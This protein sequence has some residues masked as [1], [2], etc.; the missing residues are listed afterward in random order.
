MKWMRLLSQNQGARGT[1]NAKPAALY[2]RLAQRYAENKKKPR[3]AWFYVFGSPGPRLVGL[4]RSIGVERSST[5]PQSHPTGLFSPSA[6]PK[7]KKPRSAWF[8]VFGSPGP[9]LVG[10]GRSIGVERS[11]TKPQ[12]HP[13]GLFSPS[14]TPK[15]KKPRS[16]WFYLFGSAC[17]ARTSDPMINSHL[18]YQLS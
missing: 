6:T 7:I 5:K 17:W 15:I 16:A 11:S 10:L 18:L 12:S 3:S 2:W 13:T 14:A 8:Y 9:R 4:G 1:S